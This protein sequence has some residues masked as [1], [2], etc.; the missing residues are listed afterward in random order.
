MQFTSTILKGINYIKSG[1]VY[2][3]KLPNQKIFM[4]IIEHEKIIQFID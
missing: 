4:N 3:K 1:T 2:S